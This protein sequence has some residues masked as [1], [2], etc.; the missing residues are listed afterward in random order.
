MKQRRK[1][2]VYKKS[3]DI[4]IEDVI[5][6]DKCETAN[7]ISRKNSITTFTGLDSLYKAKLREKSVVGPSFL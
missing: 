5:F 4:N 3:L 6:T 7:L 2:T 1:S